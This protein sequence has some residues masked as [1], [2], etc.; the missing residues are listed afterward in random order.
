[1]RVEFIPF[2]RR[3]AFGGFGVA[4]LAALLLSASV[5]GCATNP[6]TGQKQIS[7]IGE[8]QEIEMGRQAD[9]D[10]QATMG[11]YDDPDLQAYVGRIGQGLAAKG[12]R[13]GLPWT[14]RVVDDPT[15]NAFALPG[16]F[17]YV[18][19]GILAYL[20]SEAELAGVLGHEIGHVTARHSVSRISQQQL[21][22]LGL[23]IGMI[24]SPDV[25]R[26]GNLLQ[27]GLGLLFLQ[28]TRGDESQADD[29]AV[30]YTTRAGYDPRPLT[31]T[32]AVLDRVSQ[33]QGDGRVP[34]WLS[35]HPAP[36]NRIQNIE[37]D[38]DSIGGSPAGAVVNREGYLQ[39][40]DG[41]VFGD[42]PREGFFRGSTFFHPG[43]AFHVD[44]PSGWK[45]LNQKQQVL[46]VSPQQDAVAAV[47]LASQSS[48]EQ[49]ARAF[50]SQSAV[51]TA[52]FSSGR[53]NGIP[54]VASRFEAATQSGTLRGAVAFVDYGGRVLELIGYAP[55]SQWGFYDSSVQRFI[56][57]F[58]RETDP[59]ILSVRPAHVETIRLDR[60]TT[61]SQLA[62][63]SGASAEV[64]AILNHV[65]V[66]E[67]LPAGSL[68]KRVTG[69]DHP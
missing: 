19:R 30:R 54:A 57:S 22:G 39:Q 45:T 4:T 64:L 42:D 50:A 17:I 25:A 56:Q 41:M 18:T 20:N 40:I 62:A 58:A 43:L 67:T 10:V 13:P 12:E 59:A 28:Y 26:Y 46:G 47:T 6:A 21:A 3:P 68:V 53:V 11:L 37:A 52:G 5:P 63:G 8:G 44:F 27:T 9:R 60:P 65:G 61:P 38:I 34:S 24:L 16:G 69:S 23:G 55:A 14:F 36:Q 35:T 33:Q 1:V 2:R 7:L 15:V 32:F 66:D 48:A 29:L 31:E 51:T 49:A